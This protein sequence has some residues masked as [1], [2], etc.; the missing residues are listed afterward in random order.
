MLFL[1]YNYQTAK[2]DRIQYC[3]VVFEVNKGLFLE[4]CLEN[5]TVSKRKNERKFRNMVYFGT[6]IPKPAEEKGF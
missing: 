5:S 3:N 6:K 2:T 4:E 1:S